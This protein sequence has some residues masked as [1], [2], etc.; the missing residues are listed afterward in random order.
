[1]SKTWEQ[2][3]EDFMQNA[4]DHYMCNMSAKADAERYADRKLREQPL[5]DL[6]ND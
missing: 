1:M 4:E 6:T 2:H 3:H 5:E